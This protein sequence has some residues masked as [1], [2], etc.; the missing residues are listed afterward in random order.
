MRQA[1][2]RYTEEDREVWNILFDRQVANLEG[3]V[4]NTYFEGIEA[5]GLNGKEIPNF[6]QLDAK[7][8]PITGWTIEVVK[9]MIPVEE[10]FDLLNRKRFCSSTW[11]RSRAQL[12]YLEEPDM[13]HDIFGHVPLLASPDYSNY[14][15]GMADL[16]RRYG[17]FPG[18]MAMLQRLYWFTI[19]FGLVQESGKLK[20]Y[21]AGLISSFGEVNQIYDEG[22]ELKAF[23]LMEVFGTPF[24]ND[25]VQPL[26]FVLESMQ[27]LYA[28]LPETEAI[29]QAFIAGKLSNQPLQEDLAI[30]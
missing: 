14:A 11:L 8:L 9:G 21:G 3:K 28:S 19:E 15:H 25:R 24:Q 26:Y 22:I 27:Q 18:V 5:L 23:D 13:F 17:K 16:A 20:A 7:L 29:I 10:F 4:T 2:E 1:Y 12:D 30:V 6:L